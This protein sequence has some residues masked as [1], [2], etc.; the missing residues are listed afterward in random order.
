V[1][2]VDVDDGGGGDNANLCKY[3]KYSFHHSTARLQLEPSLG[4]F[5]GIPL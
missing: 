1:D 5:I 3:F 2:V 4:G